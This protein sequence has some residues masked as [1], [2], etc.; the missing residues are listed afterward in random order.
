MYEII[1]PFSMQNRKEM[2]FGVKEKCT[3]GCRFS[4]SASFTL[5]K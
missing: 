4:S 3:L 5:T 2:T 1:T